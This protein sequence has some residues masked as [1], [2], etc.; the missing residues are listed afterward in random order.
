MNK[1]LIFKV[2]DAVLSAAKAIVKETPNLTD[3]KVLVVVETIYQGL[4]G[5]FGAPPELSAEAYAACC[6]AANNINDEFL[7][8]IP[9]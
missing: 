5:V 2:A 4:R 9:E 3:D 1:E 7:A 8:D 6:V